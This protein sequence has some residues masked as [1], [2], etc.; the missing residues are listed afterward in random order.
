MSCG[1]VIG[2]LE[3]S[4]LKFMKSSKN[5]DLK[6]FFDAKKIERYCCRR[7]FTTHVQFLELDDGLSTSRVIDEVER[8]KLK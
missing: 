7:M 6:I 3:E 2:N 1:K 8:L 4:F 5:P